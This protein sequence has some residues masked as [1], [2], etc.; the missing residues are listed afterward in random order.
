MAAR[1]KPAGNKGFIQARARREDDKHRAWKLLVGGMTVRDISRI[2]GCSLSKAH[3]L[4][5]E[6]R[7]EIP[8]RMREE[9]IAEIE[10]RQRAI[11]EAHWEKRGTK[12]SAEIIQKSDKIL[13][14]MLGLAEPTKTELA[15]DIRVE[16][17]AADDV[18]AAL[19][20]LAAK[21]AVG[22]GGTKPDT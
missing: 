15:A 17:G 10:N 11:V 6:A 14:D 7:T 1:R 12:D 22:G 8:E 13:I 5:C 2:I 19:A 3:A 16:P 20:A 9:R 21:G 18:L 4:V